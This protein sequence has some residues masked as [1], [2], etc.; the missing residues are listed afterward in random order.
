MVMC[1]AVGFGVSG[2]AAAEEEEENSAAAS[3]SSSRP[4]RDTMGTCAIIALQ[5]DV[6]VLDAGA[7][8]AS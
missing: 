5:N 3:S 4:S 6:R 8:V 2:E 7:A 1:T